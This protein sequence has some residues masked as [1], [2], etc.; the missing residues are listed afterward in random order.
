MNSCLQV[1]LTAIDHLEDIV[2]TGSPLWD[3]LLWLQSKGHSIALDPTDIKQLILNTERE[4]IASNNIPQNNM[5]FDLGNLDIFSDQGNLSVNQIGQQDCREFF[6]CLDENR[7][8]WPD[9]FNL[10]K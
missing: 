10:F 7:D 4:R 3:H 6:C 9:V 8:K 2:E 1:I 5:L